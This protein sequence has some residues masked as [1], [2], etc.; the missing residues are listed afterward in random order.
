MSLL[1]G[2]VGVVGPPV[3]Y[4]AEAPAGGPVGVPTDAA[5]GYPK[6]DSKRAPI[7][8]PA[9]GPNVDSRAAEKGGG[10]NGCCRSC[11]VYAASSVGGRKP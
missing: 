7:E 11:V 8:L 1:A 9:G 5:S 6:R 2:S 3:K 10:S 4:P